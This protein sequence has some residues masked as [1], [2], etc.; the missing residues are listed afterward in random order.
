MDVIDEREVSFN[1]VHLFI[2]C[3]KTAHKAVFN[4]E[5]LSMLPSRPKLHLRIPLLH[6]L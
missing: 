4:A 1:Q 3:E 2:K 6:K 5:V